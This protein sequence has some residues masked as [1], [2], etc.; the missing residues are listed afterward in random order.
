MQIFITA[1]S[2]RIGPAVVAELL[3][4]G[5][6]AL[7]LARSAS[8]TTALETAGAKTIRGDLADLRTLRAG[9]ADA[10]G[11]IHLAFANDFRS[12]A[13]LATAVAEERAARAALG[14]ALIHSNRPLVTVS[15]TPSAPGR[16]PTA[17]DPL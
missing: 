11:V 9:A 15:G 2:G 16:G 10:D 5:H 13:A 8:S 12:P 6:T 4:N 14:E 3:G 7:A 17:S 1:G